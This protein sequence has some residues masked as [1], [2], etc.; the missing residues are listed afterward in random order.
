MLGLNLVSETHPHHTHNTV[1]VSSVRN[2]ASSDPNIFPKHGIKKQ[3]NDNAD[4]EA[5]IQAQI[6]KTAQFLYHQA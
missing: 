4:L 1:G 3:K 6:G 2:A 5:Y